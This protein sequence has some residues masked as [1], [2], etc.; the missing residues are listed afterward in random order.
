MVAERNSARPSDAARFREAWDLVERLWDATLER[1]RRLDPALPHESF[2]GE[3]SF[4]ETL[5]HLVLVTDRWIRRTVLG[6]PVA[7]ASAG[8]A[9][10]RSGRDSEPAR[11]QTRDR[12]ARPSLDTVLEL[13]RDRMATMRELVTALTDESL[14]DG[15]KPVETAGWPESR[16]YRVGNLLLHVLHDEWEHRLYAER[17]PGRPGGTPFVAVRTVAA[18]RPLGPAFRLVTVDSGS[19]RPVGHRRAYRRPDRD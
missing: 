6:D 15:T 4:I 7:M 3:W 12:D 16:S 11:R 5:R 13:R 17:G 18:R 14:D 2:D 1:A 19:L 10:G 9:V 8:P